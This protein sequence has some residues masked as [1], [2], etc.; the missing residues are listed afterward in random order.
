MSSSVRTISQ[1]LIIDL[2]GQSF[3]LLDY[4]NQ[5]LVDSADLPFNSAN[6]YGKASL[7]PAFVKKYLKFL[8]HLTQIRKRTTSI[9]SRSSTIEP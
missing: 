1:T 9:K 5:G 6:P 3:E 8:F 7:S 2:E 4:A